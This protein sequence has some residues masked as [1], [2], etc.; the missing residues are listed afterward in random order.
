MGV[1]TCCRSFGFYRGS[2]DNLVSL[3][4][5]LW[6]TQVLRITV[7]LDRGWNGTDKLEQAGVARVYSVVYKFVR[8]AIQSIVTDNS[9]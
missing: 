9:A 3:V 1:C 5:I 8:E 7:C 4:A 2:S 6:V